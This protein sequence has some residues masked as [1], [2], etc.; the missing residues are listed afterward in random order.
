MQTV[1]TGAFRAW[2][3][4]DGAIRAVDGEAAL[5]LGA[6]AVKQEA[7]SDHQRGGLVVDRAPEP[8][9]P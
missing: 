7:L 8:D 1:E 3:G 6:R 5:L 9:D 4:G 2:P